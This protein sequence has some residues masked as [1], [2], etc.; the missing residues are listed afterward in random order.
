[1]TLPASEP[2]SAFRESFEA[3]L[4]ADSWDRL[5]EVLEQHPDLMLPDVLQELVEAAN[6]ASRRGEHDQRVWYLL[7]ADLMS[8]CSK[9]GVRAGI[10]SWTADLKD[11]IGR[12]AALGI[13]YLK[14]PGD[15]LNDALESGMWGLM[16]ARRRGPFE[17]FWDSILPSVRV[18]LHE[19]INK[20]NGGRIVREIEARLLMLNLQR[21]APDDPSWTVRLVDYAGACAAWFEWN[22]DPAALRVAISSLSQAVARDPKPDWIS[23]LGR[24]YLFRF[25]VEGEDE[26]RVAAIETQRSVLAR[27]EEITQAQYAKALERLGMALRT[28]FERTGM[29]E[30]ITEA[31]RRLKAALRLVPANDKTRPSYLGNLAAALMTEYALIRDENE[32]KR[33]VKLLRE[34]VSLCSV[35][36]ALRPD[37]LANLGSCLLGIDD[38]TDATRTEALP[39]LREA[40]Q[41]AGDRHVRWQ[42]EL[43]LCN[44]LMSDESEA[45]GASRVEAERRL[46]TVIDETDGS[47]PDRAAAL[48]L[49]GKLLAG[50]NP[51]ESRS[52]LLNAAETGATNRPVAAL[53][54]IQ[55]LHARAAANA[56]VAALK[57]VSQRS[58]DILDGLSRSQ[59]S[60]ENRTLWRRTAYR[61]IEDLAFELAEGGDPR[62]AIDH[63]ERGR[64]SAIRI[65]AE[66]EGRDEIAA[67]DR[68]AISDR[69]CLVHL[70]AGTRGGTALISVDDRVSAHPLPEFTSSRVLD[71]I[72]QY[73]RLQDDG[74]RIGSP[75]IWRS[76]LDLAARWVQ[77]VVVAAIETD[78][79]VIERPIALLVDGVVGMLPWASAWA[80]E[81]ADPAA[82]RY[83]IDR[84]TTLAFA[85]TAAV[86]AGAHHAARVSNASKAVIIAPLVLGAKDPLFFAEREAAMIQAHLPGATLLRAEATKANVLE[87]MRD[88]GLIHFASHGRADP[89]HPLA[90]S[91]DLANGEVL[92]VVDLWD[93]PSQPRRLAVLSACETSAAGLMASTESIGLPAAFLRLGF[94]GVVGSL[95]PVRDDATALIMSRFYE[96]WTAGTPPAE[97][98]AGAQRWLRCVSRREASDL[99]GKQIDGDAPFAHIEFW[100]GFTY[101][102][103]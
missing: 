96:Q 94:G 45:G 78:L 66:R 48:A 77:R 64:A 23:D 81:E 49:L 103:V 21:V 67:E 29:V 33:A 83:F 5:A 8:A 90:S 46:R 54:A 101:T 60:V 62:A 13:A 91:I 87:A 36:H 41:L 55:E 82:R 70:V 12:S 9:Q 42:W 95:W 57:E 74:K 4:S 59:G 68:R 44:G 30:E 80:P 53:L 58:L 16:G 52:K 14:G 79:R 19:W 1:M 32:W 7:N 2:R 97:A 11:E 31:V 17:A 26:D 73:L 89:L 24:L 39:A 102:G 100:G 51:E 98:L 88:A 76:A 72:A 65:S 71:V 10:A 84:P 99:L 75:V 28:S 43:I 20:H 69:F 40:I 61:L 93:A 56:D 6:A 22:G 37:A 25:E 18:L 35:G 34:E 63:L 47:W 27:R 86:L 3:L 85:P 38:S 50:R 15:G 92:R